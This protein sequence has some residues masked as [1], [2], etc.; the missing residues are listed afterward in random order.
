MARWL[1]GT[2]FGFQMY[3]LYFWFHSH[4]GPTVCINM[5]LWFFLSL[6]HTCIVQVL[7]DIINFLELFRRCFKHSHLFEALYAKFLS[8]NL[9]FWSWYSLGG[10]WWTLCCLLT[11]TISMNCPH[12]FWS[13]DCFFQMPSNSL[14]YLPG[15][16]QV[17]SRP[18]VKK[19]DRFSNSSYFHI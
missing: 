13:R 8:M 7:L 4:S 14:R 2:R 5:F 10:A 16:M 1:Y 11:A 18:F 3:M 9:S 12:Y 15:T 19:I 6:A 17:L